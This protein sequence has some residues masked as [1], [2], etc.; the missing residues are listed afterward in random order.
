MNGWMDGCIAAKQLDKSNSRC[1]FLQVCGF[2]Q[3]DVVIDRRLK[4]HK[5]RDFRPE[6]HVSITGLLSNACT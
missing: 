3:S 4:P 5:Y 1:C 6:R 2:S